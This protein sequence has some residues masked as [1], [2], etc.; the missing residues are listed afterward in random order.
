M[1]DFDKL[2]FHWNS[3]TETWDLDSGEKFDPSHAVPMGGIIEGVSCDYDPSMAL[4]NLR[5]NVGKRY[6]Y[7]CVYTPKNTL[8]L[9]HIHDGDG[10]VCEISPCYS[11][12]FFAKTIRVIPRDVCRAV[13]YALNEVLS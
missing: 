5:V 12:F 6:E 13:G 3:E 9:S 8:S 10:C 2:P 7:L 4:I 11:S 1:E